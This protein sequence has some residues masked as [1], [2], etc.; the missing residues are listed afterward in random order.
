M[1]SGKLRT[2]VL[3]CLILTPIVQAISKI[4]VCVGYLRNIDLAKL[5]YANEHE[6]T[7]GNE[8]TIEQLYPYINMDLIC[9]SGGE[10][11][12]GP[13]GTPARCTYP[14]HSIEGL[15]EIQRGIVQ[16]HLIPSYYAISIIFPATFLAV[17]VFRKL[18]T[19]I[20][21]KKL[22][23]FP[24]KSTFLCAYIICNFMLLGIWS[25]SLELPP[26]WLKCLFPILI[27]VPKIYW[28]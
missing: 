9:P 2:A 20:T 13:I 11:I 25:D 21:H 1:I 7:T 16:E 17:Y 22:K 19:V 23:R 15:R 28:L 4:G 27:F 26:I 14:S 18:K 24:Y 3:L 10:Y 5:M 6:V 12:I 8:V